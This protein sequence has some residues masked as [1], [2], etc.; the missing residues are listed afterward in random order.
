[1]CLAAAAGGAAALP[2]RSAGLLP[3]AE[4]PLHERGAADLVRADTGTFADGDLAV[5]LG[6]DRLRPQSRPDLPA[7][8]RAASTLLY[9]E[10]A[11][12]A[13][14]AEPAR[15]DGAAW[16]LPVPRPGS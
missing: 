7:V 11:G 15:A 10:S 1:V 4:H 9:P 2:V 6:G 13:L 8:W 16:A 12:H 5:G 3:A 14:H